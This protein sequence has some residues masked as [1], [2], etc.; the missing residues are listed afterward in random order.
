M[1][2]DHLLDFVERHKEEDLDPHL[3]TQTYFI[4][5]CNDIDVITIENIKDEWPFKFPYLNSVK[6][7]SIDSTINLSI[8]QKNRIYKIYKI[9]FEKFNYKK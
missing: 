7:K 5:K 8:N 4:D 2:I 6:N 3:K 1:S 9:D